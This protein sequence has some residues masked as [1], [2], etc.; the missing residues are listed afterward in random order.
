[1]GFFVYDVLTDLAYGGGGEMLKNGS[2]PDDI[3]HTLSEAFNYS[4]TVSPS[5]PLL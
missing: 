3:L 5:K 1:M 4:G 2:D